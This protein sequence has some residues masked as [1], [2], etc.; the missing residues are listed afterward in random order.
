MIIE[1]ISLKNWRGYRELYSFSFDKGFNLV[2]GRNEAGKSTLFEAL[3][4]I[5]F[6]RYSSK[7]EEIR[8]IQ[9]LNSTLGPEAE[10]IFIDNGN[11]LKIKKRFL[12]LPTC[13]FYTE[14]NGHWDLDHE[15]DKADIEL[16][17]ILKGNSSGRATQSEHRGL[18]QA[19]WYL[20]KEDSLPKKVWADGLKQN[21]A[22]IIEFVV[23]RP[24]ED[25]I[26]SKIDDLYNVYYTFQSGKIKSGSEVANL[27]DEIDQKE[28]ELGVLRINAS[29]VESLRLELEGLYERKK[30]KQNSLLEAQ[31]ELDQLKNQL[32][33]ADGIED[34]KRVKESEV[35]QVDQKIKTLEMDLKTIDRRINSI[36]VLNKELS[37]AKEIS[38]G[39]E[40]DSRIEQIAEEKYH[41]KWKIEFEPNLKKIDEELRISYAIENL[42]QLSKEKEIVKEYLSKISLAHEEYRIKKKELDELI[43]P[44]KHEWDEFEDIWNNLQIL[45]AEARASAIRIKFD[46]QIKDLEITANPSASHTDDKQ[47]YLVLSATTFN[48][49]KVGKIHIR[50]GGSTLEEINDKSQSLRILIQNTFSRFNVKD[51]QALSD[52]YQNRIDLYKETKQLK[53]NL[54]KIVD[55][56]KNKN[57]DEEIVSLEREIAE[58]AQSIHGAPNNW[59]NMSGKELREQI[60]QLE[61]TKKQIIDD[62]E[63]EQSNEKTSRDKYRTLNEH[64]I[65]ER[66]KFERCNSEIKSLNNEN[67][68]LLNN[69]GTRDH[70]VSL[71]NQNREI[72]STLTGDLNKILVDYEKCVE[73]PRKFHKDRENKVFALKEQ[74]RDVE[75]DIIDRK[76]R[77]EE[78]AAQGLYSQISDLEVLLESKKRRLLSVQLEA[79]S[80]KLLHDMV[81][82]LRKE[83]STMLAGPISEL[84]NRYLGILTDDTYTG[85]ELNEEL[86]PIAIQSN[87]YGTQLPLDSLSYGTYEQIVVLLRLALG[88][89]LS[90]NERN[91]VVIDDRLVNADSMRMKRL[92]QILQEVSNNSCQIIVATCNDTPYLGIKGRVISVPSD[93]KI[94]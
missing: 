43:A 61:K 71:I 90:K 5:M 80:I 89:I 2:V 42:S 16:Q 51:K 7:A 39:C 44:S 93:G 40:A 11:R 94:S 8:K 26:C 79:D 67:A 35:N 21:L 49:N 50:G 12:H 30:E 27:K 37:E 41:H 9:P 47:E 83:Q 36:G 74:I 72:L 14:R 46:L 38:E 15:G 69:Y 62:I 22:G 55:E 78:S 19:L 29:N 64:A 91:L 20:Q 54:E 68:Q 65:E 3:T 81:V 28:K 52:L 85:L 77:I 60:I 48:I 59:K 58:K 87:R 84:V 31:V 73:L 18:A 1:K 13:E 23:K 75:R 32:E 70:L 88:V 4:R 92:S 17:K 33:I 34:Q 86:L 63:S 45:D 10:L 76:A 6:D 66:G 24:E 53:K 56:G 25:A 57:H 82:A